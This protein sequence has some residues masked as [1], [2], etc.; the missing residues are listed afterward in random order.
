[1]VAVLE[2]FFVSS[3]VDF[4]VV[5]IPLVVRHLDPHE[6]AKLFYCLSNKKK[7]VREREGEVDVFLFM[8]SL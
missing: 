7:K 4:K 2:H 1:M 5:K 6:G 8:P 3:E